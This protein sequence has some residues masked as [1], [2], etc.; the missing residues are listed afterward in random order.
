MKSTIYITTDKFRCDCEK[1]I[2]ENWITLILSCCQY[3]QI[4]RLCF[5]HLFQWIARPIGI[6]LPSPETGSFPSFRPPRTQGD[7]HCIRVISPLKLEQ[8][9]RQRERARSIIHSK[10]HNG[11]K[12][13]PFLASNTLNLTI[14]FDCVHPCSVFVIGPYL[15]R[16]RQAQLVHFRQ[17]SRIR[18][19]YW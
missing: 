5:L 19:H 14:N 15:C 18:D 16:E 10:L 4:M 17:E 11:K 2:N 7:T 9:R 8:K 12:K 6:Q 3:E 1:E 13:L